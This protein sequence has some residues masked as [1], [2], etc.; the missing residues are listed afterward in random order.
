[1]KTEHKTFRQGVRAIVCERPMSLIDL[2]DFTLEQEKTRPPLT[3]LELIELGSLWVNEQ[4][5]LNPALMLTQGDEVRIHTL[6]RRFQQP[7]DLLERI[8]AEDEDSLLIEKPA[9]LPAE[10]LPDNARENLVSFLED[11]RGQSFFSTHRLEAESEGLMLIAKTLEAQSRLRK[12][13][14]DGSIRRR[15]VAFVESLPAQEPEPSMRIVSTDKLEARTNVITERRSSW[16]IEGK[17]LDLIYRLEIEFT[18]LRPKEVRQ[19]LAALGS[20]VIGDE[21]HGSRCRLVDVS[22]GKPAMAFIASSL[23]SK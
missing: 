10:P 9:G 7:K 2:V 3:P 12:A 6:P 15:Y 16:E 21:A 13:F 11:V 18:S 4:R 8:L 17:P 23:A 14:A 22:S 5:M 19:R 20:P 1:M